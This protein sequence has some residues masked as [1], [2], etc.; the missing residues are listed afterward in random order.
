MSFDHPGGNMHLRALSV[1][2]YAD[3]LDSG[4]PWAQANYGDGEWACLMGEAGQNVNGEQYNQTLGAMLRATLLQPRDF[5]YGTRPGKK[6]KHTANDWVKANCS[7]PIDW[8]WKSTLPE[9]NVNGQL[10]PF[11]QAWKRRD[12]VVVGP[13]H[14]LS[15]LPFKYRLHHTIPD[16]TAW[17][18]WRDIARKI[19]LHWREGDV[20][21]FSAG[22]ASN[23]M[24]WW[25]WDDARDAGVTLL[26]V[27]ALWDPYVGVLSRSGYRKPTWPESMERNVA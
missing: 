1:Q 10:A 26:D 13:V 3:L 12:I 7:R 22:M 27:G 2:D 20:V 14:T 11:M 6:R 17:M 21:S 23:V 25:L 5:M 19:R 9:A 24:I 18:H 8:V 4:E 16:G 15:G